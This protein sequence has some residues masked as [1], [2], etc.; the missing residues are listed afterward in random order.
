MYSFTRFGMNSFTRVSPVSGDWEAWYFNGRLIAEG[1]DVLIDEILAGISDILP[2][3]VGHMYI[4]DEQAEEGFPENLA[5][6]LE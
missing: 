3:T 2:N 6:I 1:H 5:E 4:T